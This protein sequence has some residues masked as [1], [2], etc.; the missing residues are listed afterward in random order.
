MRW[1]TVG[2][3]WLAIAIPV[4]AQRDFLTA[5]EADQIRVAQEANLRLK[6]YVHFAEQRMSLLKQLTAQ[7][8][9]GRSKFIHDTLEDFTKI[10]E[11]IDTVADD[12]LKR[13]AAVDEGM[14]AVASAEKVLLVELERIEESKPK[15]AGRY[16]F[17][18]TTAIE[19]TR[20][21][22]E[23]SLED[24]KE[25]KAEV[26]TKAREEKKEREALM[27]PEDAAERR[28]ADKKTAEAETKKKAP[29]LRR[30]GEVVKQP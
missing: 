20:D 18:L 25:R 26:L 13:G 9:P 30:K 19:T 5:D 8:K 28:A 21:S 1:R 24:L 15:D 16:Q 22:L 14:A 27:T 17:V 3:V 2:A 6:L 11:A 12:A 23:M 10:I 7:D 4:L 29:T